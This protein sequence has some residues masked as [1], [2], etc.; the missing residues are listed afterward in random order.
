MFE[1]EITK[2]VTLNLQQGG[3]SVK[4]EKHEKGGRVIHFSGC[5]VEGGII[6]RVG[7]FLNRKWKFQKSILKNFTSLR[8]DHEKSLSYSGNYLTDFLF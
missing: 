8:S 2:G 3:Y 7:Q 6:V 1:Y 4:L 5:L